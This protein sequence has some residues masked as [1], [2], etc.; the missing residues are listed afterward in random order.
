MFN[1]RFGTNLPPAS[2]SVSISVDGVALKKSSGQSEFVIPIVTSEMS[3]GNHN[4]TITASN[5]SGKSTSR[6]FTLVVLEK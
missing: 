5:K 3:L 1:L 6:S 2:G 4:V